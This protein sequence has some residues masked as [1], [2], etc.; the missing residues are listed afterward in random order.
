MSYKSM[1]ER[2]S[3]L[4]KTGKGYDQAIHMERRWNGQL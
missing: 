3:T 2:Q 1:T 4:Y